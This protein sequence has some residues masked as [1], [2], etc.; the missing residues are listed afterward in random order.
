[1]PSKEWLTRKIKYLGIH[2]S[3]YPEL[4]WVVI[5]F[6]AGSANAVA[7]K[8]FIDFIL[9]FYQ[10]LE[11]NG[12]S[13]LALPNWQFLT[14]IIGLFGIGIFFIPIVFSWAF[15]R[16][17]SENKIVP[18]LYVEI[19]SFGLL[20]YFFYNQF[21]INLPILLAIG[22]YA[23]LGGLFQDGIV[24]YMFG[25]VVYPNDVVVRSLTIGENIGEVKSIVFSK[26]FLRLNNLKKIKSKKQESIKL[27]SIRKRG[28][29]YI[30]ELKEGTTDKETVI[31]LLFF[32]MGWYSVNPIT[33]DSF[34]YEW[35]LTRM[36][37]L[38]IYLSR[39]LS[40]EVKEGLEEN[41]K[42]LTNYF[43]EDMAG[44]VSHFQEFSFRRQILL[45]VAIALIIVSII[46]LFFG[47][48]EIGL[49]ILL[50]GIALI[51]DL[52]LRE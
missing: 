23:F 44:S 27:R 4:F 41:T 40:M 22:Y 48:L 37:E 46:P 8:N 12:V 17:S 42:L 15:S 18:P 2:P 14:L 49:V 13:Y 19:V 51:A 26:D 29:S 45:I 35:A 5:V 25:S 16:V 1:M 47:F 52:A 39:K 38:K 3:G 31:N 50:A 11:A 24:T 33:R 28:L 43:I 36:D 10:Y 34:A 7:L 20:A 6:L 9:P 30:L 21:A 32:D